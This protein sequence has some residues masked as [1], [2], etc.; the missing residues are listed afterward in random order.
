[1]GGYFTYINMPA[2]SVRVAA[3]RAGVDTHA[4]YS[5]NGYSI[6]GS[7]AYAPGQITI[8]YRSN[9]GAAG[10]SITGQTSEWNSRNVLDNVV[11]PENED[12]E[13][14]NAGRVTVYRYGDRA[15]WVSN[16]VLYTLNGNDLLSSEQ[17]ERIALSV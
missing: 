1:L 10:Y 6:D 17:I 15:A 12:Y 8:K 7:V 13:T 2:I 5:P 3:N 4:P 9:T 14:L 16:G 11:A